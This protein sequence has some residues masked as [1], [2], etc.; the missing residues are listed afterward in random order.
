MQEMSTFAD[1]CC[2][3]KMICRCPSK[4]HRALII[5][6]LSD[7]FL[8]ICKVEI[9]SPLDCSL[10]CGSFKHWQRSSTGV[11]HEH[12]VGTAQCA[13][14]RQVVKSAEVPCIH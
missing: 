12:A 10:A 9:L 6:T 14:P 11:Q 8:S 5:F 13:S 2:S 1:T 7:C 3:M 4:L